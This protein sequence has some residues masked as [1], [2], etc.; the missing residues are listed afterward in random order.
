MSIFTTIKNKVTKSPLE[1]K[2]DDLGF[3]KEIVDA[4]HRAGVRKASDIIRL[5]EKGE[6]HKVRDIG[7]N[8]TRQIIARI[9]KVCET[10]FNAEKYFDQHSIKKFKM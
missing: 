4:L 2:L 10:D 5:I 6:L 7:K 3:S 9:N 1:T 8:K